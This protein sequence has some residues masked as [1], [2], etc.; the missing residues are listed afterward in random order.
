MTKE[1]VN[2]HLDLE[3]LVHIRIYKTNA[4]LK[5]SLFK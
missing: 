3:N 1:L 4:V 5:R 2:I